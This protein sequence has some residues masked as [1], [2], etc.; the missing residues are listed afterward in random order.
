MQIINESLAVSRTQ[1]VE[2]QAHQ[3]Q[4]R[5]KLQTR[6]RGKTTE[7]YPSFSIMKNLQATRT[8]N[9]HM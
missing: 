1:R 9:L 2:W 3:A 7:L 5:A 6:K 8:R 4:A